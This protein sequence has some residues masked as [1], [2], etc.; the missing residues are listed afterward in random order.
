MITNRVALGAACAAALFLAGCQSK[1][2]APAA[3]PADA[4]AVV[5]GHTITRDDVDR[6]F[7]QTSDPAQPLSATETLTAKAGVLDDL[8]V[9]ELLAARA[10]QEN[11]QVADADVD[12][13]FADARQNQT[14]QAFQQ[15]LAARKLTTDDV[16]EGLR[17]RL[18]AQKAIDHD[19]N[20]KVRIS[21]QEITDAFN[22]NRAQFNLPED[23]LHLAQIIVTPVRD[24]QIV[25]STGDDATTPDAARAKVTMLMQR[26]Q[27]GTPFADLA[28]NYSEDAESTPRGGDLGLVPMS[29]IR[30]APAPLRDAVLQL[31]PGK[32]RVVN[33]GGA[34]T[35]IYVVS[36]EP[37]GQR[38]L[39]TP[40]V[41]DQISQAL[42]AQRQELLRTAYLAKLRNDARITNYL[43]RNIIDSQGR[44]GDPQRAAAK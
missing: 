10:R 22:A 29:A 42:K 15:Q 5:N 41:K 28:R 35:I 37:A 24:Q 27:E 21:D 19:V 17:R 13:A 12:K 38:D 18:L 8:I 36:R 43:A 39:S 33:Q 23:A 6:A 16:R 26:L 40:G 20:D 11:L 30:Q 3:P 34:V 2:A 14:D 7:R 25:N 32:A 44:S 9:E 4:W 31:A 1:T